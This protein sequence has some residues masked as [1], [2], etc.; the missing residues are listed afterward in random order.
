VPVTVKTVFLKLTIVTVY[1]M[2]AFAIDIFKYI[3][4]VY[5][6]ELILKLAL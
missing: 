2:L 6:R 4:M 1:L 3:Y 5:L